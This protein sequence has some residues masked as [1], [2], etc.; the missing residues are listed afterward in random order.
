MESPHQQVQELAPPPA[1]QAA[2]R[3]P[4]RHPARRVGLLDRVAMFVGVQLVAW[5]RRPRAIPSHESRA[6]QLRLNRDKLIRE[7]AAE[8][9]YYGMLS[10]QR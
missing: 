4:V 1:V 9:M 8:R 2:R 5:S 10:S 6:D 7:L 3:E